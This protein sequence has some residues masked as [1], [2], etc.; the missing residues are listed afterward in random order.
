MDGSPFLVALYED[1]SRRLPLW[2][3]RYVRLRPGDVCAVCCTHG[4]DGSPVQRR[5]FLA[6]EASNSN[7]ID[8]AVLAEW[9]TVVDAWRGG[10]GEA[11]EVRCYLGL[12]DVAGTVSYYECETAV[13]PGDA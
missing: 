12:V 5:L 7:R 13:L 8:A 3:T 2:T 11:G 9:V 1:V 10:A 4:G 6:V